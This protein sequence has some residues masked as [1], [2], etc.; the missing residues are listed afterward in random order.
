M[1][2]IFI[3]NISLKR[4]LLKQIK[5]RHDSGP[6]GVFLRDYTKQLQEKNDVAPAGKIIYFD[7]CRF[8]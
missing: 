1:F 8:N 3:R 6:R 7:L 5:L 4:V 2:Y